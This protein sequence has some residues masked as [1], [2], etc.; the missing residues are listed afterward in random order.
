MLWKF[1][2]GQICFNSFKSKVFEKYPE[3]N[4]EYQLIIFV[5]CRSVEYSG[6]VSRGHAM[7]PP[8]LPVKWDVIL[9]ILQTQP[10]HFYMAAKIDGFYIKKP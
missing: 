8:M 3:I 7:L 9:Q 4:F 6:Y 2:S 1:I 10:F 5:L